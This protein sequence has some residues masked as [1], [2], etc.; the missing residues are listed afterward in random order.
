[1]GYIE[2]KVYRHKITYLGER[3]FLG[4]G[5]ISSIKSVVSRNSWISIAAKLESG[6]YLIAI[7][8]ALLP[9]VLSTDI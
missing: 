1:M 2:R 6:L 9:M 5:L 8:V 7:K 3:C 4:D